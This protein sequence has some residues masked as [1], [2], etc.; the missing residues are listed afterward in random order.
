MQPCYIAI[1]GPGK[2]LAICK[3]GDIILREYFKEKYSSFGKGDLAI[4]EGPHNR[5][6]SICNNKELLYSTIILQEL[7]VMEILQF[8]FLSY[9][10]SAI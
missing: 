9:S 6:H 10:N 5:K 1:F 7:N 8:S 2:I 4:S 3:G